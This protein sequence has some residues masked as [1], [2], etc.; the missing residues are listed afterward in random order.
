MAVV[1][2]V[3]SVGTSGGFNRMADWLFNGLEA[4]GDNELTD[5]GGVE[6]GWVSCDRSPSGG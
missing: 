4:L 1:S 6:T 3:V 5:G 2:G